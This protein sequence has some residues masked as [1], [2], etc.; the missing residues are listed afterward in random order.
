[1]QFDVSFFTSP[2]IRSPMFPSRKTSFMFTFS[3]CPL[4]GVKLL[5]WGQSSSC[6]PSF[7]D[8][9]AA[10]S[11]LHFADHGMRGKSVVPLALCLSCHLGP[12]NDF[13]PQQQKGFFYRGFIL[14]PLLPALTTTTL[15]GVS[16]PWT[17]CPLCMCPEGA[18]I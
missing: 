1:M 13:D 16:G 7:K 17:S 9:H 14:G 2:V 18:V 4:L 6:S 5:G 12:L 11:G 3:T 10:A 8:H 15:G